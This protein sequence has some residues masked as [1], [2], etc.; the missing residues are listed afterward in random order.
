MKDQIILFALNLV[1][2]VCI[3]LYVV[4]ELLKGNRLSIFFVVIAMISVVATVYRAYL[5]KKAVKSNDKVV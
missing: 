4:F 2:A 3:V 1:F 5:L